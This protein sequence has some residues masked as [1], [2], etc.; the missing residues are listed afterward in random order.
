MTEV[1]ES[2][3]L[4]APAKSKTSF[5]PSHRS[6]ASDSVKKTPPS[7]ADQPIPDPRRSSP[8]RDRYAWAFCSPETPIPPRQIPPP[9]RCWPTNLSSRKPTTVITHDI[10]SPNPSVGCRASPS[11]WLH[12]RL[13][14]D[15]FILGMDRL[16]LDIF[17]DDDDDDETLANGNGGKKSSKV[18]KKRKRGAV[19]VLRMPPA[20]RKG[21]EKREREVSP[22]PVGR[23]L[24]RR[25]GGEGGCC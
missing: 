10:K 5:P 11:P 17:D 14:D 1:E 19:V 7:T 20:G 16:S 8:G 12:S 22:T 15:G 13:P 6:P 4:P 23:L 2:N 18:G 25:K 24:R 9:P 21:L 3:T